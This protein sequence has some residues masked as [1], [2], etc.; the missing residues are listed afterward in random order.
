M[1]KS[2]EKILQNSCIEN[3]HGL[4]SV[5]V[6]LERKALGNFLLYAIYITVI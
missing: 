3:S 4:F 1:R 6:S 5:D 2:S